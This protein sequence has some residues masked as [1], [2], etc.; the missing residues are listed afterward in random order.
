MISAWL[1]AGSSVFIH[2]SWLSIEEARRDDVP[3]FFCG[4]NP[5]NESLFAFKALRKLPHFIF[6]SGYPALALPSQRALKK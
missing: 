2:T 6:L 4:Q 3:G 5:K 1:S